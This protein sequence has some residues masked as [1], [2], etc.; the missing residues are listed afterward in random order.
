MRALSRKL[1]FEVKSSVQKRIYFHPHLIPID[2]VH[3]KFISFSLL[4]VRN[5]YG[6]EH[7]ENRV[8]NGR[9][10]FLRLSEKQG[11]E[12]CSPLLS[13]RYPM[14]RSDKSSLHAKTKGLNLIKMKNN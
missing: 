11:A 13:R 3:I 10:A 9:Q 12:R 1:L 14:W 7:L 8:Y 5:S 4:L 2:L 6:V